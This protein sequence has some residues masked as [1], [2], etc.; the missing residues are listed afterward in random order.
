MPPESPP[1]GLGLP[2]LSPTPTS[3]CAHFAGATE[4]PTANRMAPPV[5]PHHR[6]LDSAV[7][8]PIVQRPEELRI[9]LTWRAQHL[10]SHAGQMCFPGGRADP[11]DTSLEHTALRETQE[12]VGIAAQDVQI[13]GRLGHYDT[14]SGYRINPVVGLIEGSVSPIPNPGEVAAVVEAP[15]NYFLDS[16]VY[17]VHHWERDGQRGQYYGVHF[18]GYFIWGATAAILVDLY[19]QLAAQAGP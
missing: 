4:A 1:Q 3:L 19:H 10:R 11:E 8:V 13:L 2:S 5:A 15:L 9:L 16:T 6:R 18:D 17:E 12:E 7:L 14:Q